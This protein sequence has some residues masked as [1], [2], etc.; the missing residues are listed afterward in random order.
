MGSPWWTPPPTSTR[1]GLRQS[2]LRTSPLSADT[3]ATYRLAPTR[4]ST[5]RPQPTTP[6]STHQYS[7]WPRLPAPRTWRTSTAPSHQS[8]LRASPAFKATGQ[9][10]GLPVVY[11]A[12]ISGTA[13]NYTAQCVAADQKGVKSVFIGDAS[14]IIVRVATDCTRQGYTPIYLQ[15]MGGWGLNEA[16]APGLKNTLWLE[17]PAIPFVASTPAVQA[18]NAAIGQVATPASAKTIICLWRTPFSSM[19]FRGS[20]RGR[21][22]SWRPDRQRYP[23]RGRG[24]EG[25]RLRGTEGRHSGGRHGSP[26]HVHTRQ[27]SHRR[28]LVHHQRPRRRDERAGQR[29]GYLRA[30]G[31]TGYPLRRH[32]AGVAGTGAIRP[33]PRRC[34]VWT[35]SPGSATPIMSSVF[36]ESCWATSM[37][38]PSG[39]SKTAMRTPGTSSTGP[40][41][42]LPPAATA[43]STTASR[44]STQRVR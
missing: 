42:T 44:S 43:R 27:A 28:L 41:S 7:A 32:A 39:S 24:D 34:R 36:R 9:R 17:S 5:P 13:P 35:S 20:T 33:E 3:P 8:A 23:D 11:N 15:E 16:T 6:R 26:P 1:I 4:T 29:S 10:V 19:D 14:A 12:E 31:V 38:L 2:R 18:A 40:R 37:A 22:Q 30:G 25:A 21:R